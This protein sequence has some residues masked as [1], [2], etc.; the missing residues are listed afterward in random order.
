[1]GV[2]RTMTQN[3]C[4]VFPNVKIGGGGEQWHRTSAMCNVKG[5]GGRGSNDTEPMPCVMWRGWGGEGR[6]WKQRHR[7]Q[8][9]VVGLLCSRSPS[10]LAVPH[11]DFLA[12]QIE[13]ESVASALHRLTYVQRQDC[14]R[15]LHHNHQFT[16]PSTRLDHKLRD[17]NQSHNSLS[18]LRSL[19]VSAAKSEHQTSLMPANTFFITGS[20]WSVRSVR[21]SYLLI[22]QQNQRYTCHL[23]RIHHRLFT[24]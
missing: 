15:R 18:S 11:R 20:L 10:D 6:G 14:S 17:G 13:P 4:H 12:Q 19:A 16:C 22:L 23:H 24:T 7:T 1:M 21:S 8:C 3:Q 2:E 5:W 9:H